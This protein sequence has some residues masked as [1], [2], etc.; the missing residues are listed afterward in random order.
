MMFSIDVRSREPIYLQ[1]EKSIIKYISLGIYE[2]DSPLPSVRALACDL[3]INPNTVSKAYKELE[4]RGVIYT[5]AG[6]GAY[7]S[8]T[9]LKSIHSAVTKQLHSA[10]QDAKNLGIVKDEIIQLV[11]SVWEDKNDRD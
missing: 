10:L 7:V 9:D 1:L 4:L 6:K 8:E 2:K 3:G 5:V 11:N